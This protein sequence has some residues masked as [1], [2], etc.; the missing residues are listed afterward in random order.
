MAKKQIDPMTERQLLEQINAKLGLVVGLLSI[1]GKDLDE[2]IHLL[3][4]LGHDWKTIGDLVGLKP[5][6]ARM[7]AANKTAK[8]KKRSRRQSAPAEGS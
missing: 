1:M 5:D 8:K 6:A 4:S 3:R 7:R 2:Q